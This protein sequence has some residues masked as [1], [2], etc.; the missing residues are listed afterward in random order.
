M[1]LL[2]ITGLVLFGISF[3]LKEG[4]RSKEDYRFKKDL[5]FLR[6]KIDK[7]IKDLKEI[8]KKI[9]DKKGSTND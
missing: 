8:K 3:L 9:D 1:E 6:C 2:M 4:K 7:I 5:N